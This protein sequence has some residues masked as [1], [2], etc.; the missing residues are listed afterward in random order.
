MGRETS[1]KVLFQQWLLAHKFRKDPQF[2]YEDK[3]FLNRHLSDWE[4]VL[5]D[6][7]DYIDQRHAFGV[8]RTVL[9]DPRIQNQAEKEILIK[10]ALLHD[11]GKIRGDFTI[12]QRVL[13][14]ISQL[15]PSWHKRLFKAGKRSESGNLARAVYVQA[16]HPQRGAYML[17]ISGVDEEVVELVRNHHNSISRT[18]LERCLKTADAV[19]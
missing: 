14:K 12:N 2:T 6:Q 4:R 19:N 1:L 9:N 16:I 7:M 10:A 18:R 15:F 3:N 13:V 11:I 8:A 5:F 17:L